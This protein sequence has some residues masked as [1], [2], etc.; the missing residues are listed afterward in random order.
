MS[1]KNT[2]KRPRI[3]HTVRARRE[4][5]AKFL[6]FLARSGNVTMSA[7]AVGVSRE[8]IYTLQSRSEKFAAQC[9]AAAKDAVE[10]L[11][12]A[13]WQRASIGVDEPIW[14]KDENGKPVQVDTVKRYSDTLLIF[15]L[16]ALNPAKYRE[17]VRQQISGPD[18]GPV[19]TAQQFTVV[20]LPMLDGQRERDAQLIAEFKSG[21]EPNRLL[22]PGNGGN[23][24]GSGHAGSE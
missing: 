1:A 22:T 4:W 5:R 20:E 12:A 11:E 18:G 2:P 23:G 19:M 7:Q 16:K 17:V 6:K 13:A 3:R 9:K 24:G 21:L 14:M 15:L 8:Y 10:R